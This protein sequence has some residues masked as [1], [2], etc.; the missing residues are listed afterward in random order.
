MATDLI[1]S[2]TLKIP[3]CVQLTTL[4]TRLSVDKKARW[5]LTLRYWK[6]QRALF[7]SFNP[8]RDGTLRDGTLLESRILQESDHLPASCYIEIEI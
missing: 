6:I 3:L 5:E 4:S 8:M 2:G 1:A 7:I